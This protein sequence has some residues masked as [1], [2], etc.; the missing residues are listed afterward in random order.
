MQNGGL[1]KKNI[2]KTN[3]NGKTLIT[4][5]TVVYN[6]STTLE[7]TIQSILTQ[8][9]DNLEYII[10]DGG[11]TDGTIDIIKKYEDR[12]DYWQS[13]PDIGIYDAMNK[14]ICLCNGNYINF[15]NSGD[16]FADNTV[17]EKIINIPN[18]YNIIY[19]NVIDSN[20]NL[21]PQDKLSFFNLFLEKTICHQA[22]FIK[23]ELLLENQYDTSY[24][25]ISDRKWLLDNFKKIKSYKINIPICKYDI[26][27]IS[28]N[29]TKFANE[30][31]KLQIEKFGVLG[32]IE[33]TIKKLFRKIK[34]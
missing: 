11:S 1:R 12:I 6:G 30:S 24:K 22:I 18:I 9:Y 29:Y 31:L 27:G 13:E 33:H 3:K 28:S 32:Y 16:T 23:K 5:V 10:I 14:S 17:I 34:K 15:M 2:I 26:N 21:I 8:T 20:N 19:G 25:L 4:I 7:E